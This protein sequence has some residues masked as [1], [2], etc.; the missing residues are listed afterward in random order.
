MCTSFIEKAV[1]LLINARPARQAQLRVERIMVADQSAYASLRGARALA[2]P[3]SIKQAIIRCLATW[4]G[5]AF[6]LAMFMLIGTEAA[7]GG[8]LERLPTSCGRSSTTRGS[9]CMI[10]LRG[11]GCNKARA[12]QI[13]CDASPGQR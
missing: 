8:F 7:L 10:G 9:F 4:I 13:T 12:N 3:V 11:R 1:S 2:A 5:L 6:S